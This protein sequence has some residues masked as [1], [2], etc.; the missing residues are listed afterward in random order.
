MASRQTPARRMALAGIAA[1][2]VLGVV[3]GTAP[4]A[5]AAPRTAPQAA[6][7]VQAARLADQLTALLAATPALPGTAAET[8]RQQAPDPLDELKL[9]LDK[10][11]RDATK[12]IDDVEKANLLKA[13]QDA[14]KA[15][16][17]TGNLVS[18]I[19]AV[20]ENLPAAQAQKTTAQLSA[21]FNAVATQALTLARD[22][23]DTGRHGPA[24]P[25][26]RMDAVGE[27]RAALDALRG[28]TGDLIE[29]AEDH[30]VPAATAA[31]DRVTVDA[32]V[33]VTAIGQALLSLV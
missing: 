9:A 18:K 32:G 1:L 26:A 10:L 31:A 25:A 16:Q 13:T 27:L 33:F 28:S 24:S 29:A 30:D 15:V 7:T 11:V 20:L 4:L 23:A 6:A 17:D 22:K 19:P 21:T 14:A 3:G 5:L 8:V 12:V 2:T